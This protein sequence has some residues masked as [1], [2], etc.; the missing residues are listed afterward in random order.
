MSGKVV[1]RA[2]P[3][4]DGN[5]TFN[6]INYTIDENASK[7]VY[8]AFKTLNGKLSSQPVGKAVQIK[9]SAVK[10][11]GYY[12]S[13]SVTSTVDSPRPISSSCSLS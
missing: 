6:N 7:D 4:R 1:A 9:L 5:Y 8:V 13:S 12:S 2:Y 11:V 10:G 3:S